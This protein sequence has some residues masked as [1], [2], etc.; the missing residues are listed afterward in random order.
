L[1]KVSG[2]TAAG[3]SGRR[4]D[5]YS[6]SQPERCPGSRLN[7]VADCKMDA[8]FEKTDRKKTECK[9]TAIRI[10]TEVL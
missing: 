5:A 7:E 3:S 6:N 1:A 2:G 8:D 4:M 10:R 9:K